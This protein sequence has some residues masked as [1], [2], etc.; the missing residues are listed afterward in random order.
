MRKVKMTMVMTLLTWPPHADDDHDDGIGDGGGWIKAPKENID[1]FIDG[2]LE[3]WMVGEGMHG[4]I[5][6]GADDDGIGDGGRMGQ[7]T[8]GE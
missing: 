5:D 2:W 8:E 6:E 7:G 4:C 3:G 1:A